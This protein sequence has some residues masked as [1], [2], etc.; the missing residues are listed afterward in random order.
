MIRPQVETGTFEYFIRK[1]T[2][3]RQGHRHSYM[4][5]VLERLIICH[6]GGETSRFLIWGKVREDEQVCGGHR[7]C[8]GECIEHL[9]R[10][11][12]MVN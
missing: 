4:P 5:K 2:S 3:S 6:D 12:R 9:C 10:A 8:S 7:Q 11:Y 1:K